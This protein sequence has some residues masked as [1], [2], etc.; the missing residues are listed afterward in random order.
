MPNVTP[1]SER[2][3]INL[4]DIQNQLDDFKA[5]RKGMLF[6]G[7]I[8]VPDI[9]FSK[10]DIETLIADAGCLG[11][12]VKMALDSTKKVNVYLIPKY[13]GGVGTN[14]GPGVGHGPS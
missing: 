8:Q 2:I 5:L 9:I 12:E 1:N 6:G 13:D 14:P 4:V 10:Q 11:L 7:K 3:Y